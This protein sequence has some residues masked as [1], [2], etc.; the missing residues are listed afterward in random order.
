[1]FPEHDFFLNLL[2]AADNVETANLYEP[3]EVIFHDTD[4]TTS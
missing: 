3:M 1:M 4:E 2:F